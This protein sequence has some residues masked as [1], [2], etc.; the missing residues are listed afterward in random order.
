MTDNPPLH[1]HTRKP[2]RPGVY[3]IVGAEVPGHGP[4]L[5]LLYSLWDGEWWRSYAQHLRNAS[6][7]GRSPS[8]L[9]NSRAWFEWRELTEEELTAIAAAVLNKD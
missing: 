5:P 1:S 8:A 7:P 4:L 6:S 2:D 9:N 3:A